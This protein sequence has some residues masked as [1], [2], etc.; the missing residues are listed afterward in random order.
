MRFIKFSLASNLV[1][2][3]LFSYVGVKLWWYGDL[4]PKIIQPGDLGVLI[5]LFILLFLFISNLIIFL[6]IVKE[7]NYHED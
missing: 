6:S 7:E 2:L 5:F 3:G 1:V 4:S